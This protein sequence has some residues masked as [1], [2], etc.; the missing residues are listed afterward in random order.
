MED[1]LNT[2]DAL[3]QVL[4]LYGQV[5]ARVDAK[6]PPQEV[7]DLLATARL[8]G[9]VLGLSW[10]PPEETVLARRALA[11]ARKGIDPAW[12]AER[13]AARIAARKEK[14]FADADAV[15]AEVA[16]KGVEL[17]DSAAGTDW[18]VPA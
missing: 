3:A 18:R 11:A 5:N 8:L 4:A 13:I 2:A 7:A 15:R 1:D 16:A 6:A 17:R 14:R 12:V 9:Q 10:R